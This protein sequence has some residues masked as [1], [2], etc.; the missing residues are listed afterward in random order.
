M[1]TSLPS[2]QPAPRPAAFQAK[3]PQFGSSHDALIQPD[4][5]A[6]GGGSYDWMAYHGLPFTLSPSASR[7]TTGPKEDY[8]PPPQKPDPSATAGGSYDWL[9]YHRQI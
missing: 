9:A 3:T 7:K 5:S 4:P 8:T 6:E 2:L 1:Q